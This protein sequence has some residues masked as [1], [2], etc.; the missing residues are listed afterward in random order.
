[1]FSLLD[2]EEPLIA[3]TVYYIRVTGEVM[4]WNYD[5][6]PYPRGSAWRDGTELEFRDH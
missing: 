3:D 6:D 1:V 4:W 5:G 2:R